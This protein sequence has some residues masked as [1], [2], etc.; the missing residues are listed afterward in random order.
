VAPIVFDC[1]YY[2][3]IETLSKITTW[4]VLRKYV[5][6]RSALPS[7]VDSVTCKEIFPAFLSADRQANNLENTG[8]NEAIRSS[9][10]LSQ[11]VDHRH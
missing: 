1:N 9:H 6:T 7:L 4:R 2:N 11:S 10:H 5:L 8:S 3:E